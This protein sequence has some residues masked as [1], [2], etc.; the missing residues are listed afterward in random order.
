MF[1]EMISEGLGGSALTVGGAK[2][3]PKGRKDEAY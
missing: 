2:G 1:P 3:E